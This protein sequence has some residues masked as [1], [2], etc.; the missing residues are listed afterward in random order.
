MRSIDCGE[1]KKIGLVSYLE[2]LGIHPAR[3]WGENYWYLSLLR[4]EYV[5]SFK[6]NRVRNLW[7]DFNLGR[8]GSIIDLGTE[9]F[10]CSV[11]KFLNKVSGQEN[12]FSFGQQQKKEPTENQ[13]GAN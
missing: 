13:R 7:Y 8:G 11:P 3:V 1:A 4:K 9:M 5:P 6:I 2:S 12:F 10:Q